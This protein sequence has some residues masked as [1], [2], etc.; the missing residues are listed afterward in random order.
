VLSHHTLLTFEY[1][2]ER[3]ASIVAA[4]VMHE[5]GDIDGDRTRVSVTHET[6]VVEIDLEAT[7]PVALR[8]AIN[9][10][11]SLIEVAETVAALGSPGIEKSV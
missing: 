2:D 7:D 6:S 10:W 11:C 8:A 1:G 3:R 5:A 9:T 4:S